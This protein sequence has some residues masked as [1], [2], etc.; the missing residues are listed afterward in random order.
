MEVEPIPDDE[1]LAEALKVL[2]R[3]P[4]LLAYHDPDPS[5]FSGIVTPFDLL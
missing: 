5:I 3:D 1:S 4:I 2:G